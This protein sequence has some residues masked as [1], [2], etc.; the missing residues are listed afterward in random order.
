M[1]KMS[2]DDITHAAG[3]AFKMGW[4]D[5]VAGKRMKHRQEVFDILFPAVL[6]YRDMHIAKLRQVYGAGYDI[7]HM[8]N[9]INAG[10]LK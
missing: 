6:S 1:D 10:V 8:V 3:E 5:A 7:G 4:S 9:R 2:R